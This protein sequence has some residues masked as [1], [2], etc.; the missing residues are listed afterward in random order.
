MF[1]SI[2]NLWQ[3]AGVMLALVALYLV[4]TNSG[5][6]AKVLSAAGGSWNSV[7][8]TLQGR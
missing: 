2:K 8:R 1:T 4:L 3:L 7:L 5:G 6:T